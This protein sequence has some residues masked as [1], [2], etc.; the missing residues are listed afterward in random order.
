MVETIYGKFLT[1]E[2]HDYLICLRDSGVT[3][4]WGAGPY[5]QRE[6]GVNYEDAKNILLE[7]IDYMSKG[8]K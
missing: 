6:F 2:H 4:M 8:G 3:N 1:Q 7:W 5:I